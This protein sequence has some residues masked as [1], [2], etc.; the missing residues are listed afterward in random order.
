LCSGQ[1]K[2]KL[3]HQRQGVTSVLIRFRGSRHE[4]RYWKYRDWVVVSNACLKVTTVIYLHTNV[5][6]GEH[7]RFYL[8]FD[9]ETSIIRKNLIWLE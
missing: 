5:I 3:K 2:I 1:G 8:I 7:Q 4:K 6:Q 9:I